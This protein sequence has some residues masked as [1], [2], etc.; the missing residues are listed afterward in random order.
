MNPFAGALVDP[1]KEGVLL[2]QLFFREC[3]GSKVCDWLD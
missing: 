1:S 2:C 3:S